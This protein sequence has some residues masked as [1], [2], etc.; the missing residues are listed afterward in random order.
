MDDCCLL[1]YEVSAR[2]SGDNTNRQQL[3][4]KKMRI[5]CVHRYKE[6]TVWGTDLGVSTF[7]M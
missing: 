4:S 3:V 2:A 6:L 7:P 1:R 5:D